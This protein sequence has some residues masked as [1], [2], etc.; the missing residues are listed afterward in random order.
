LS[1]TFFLL[2]FSGF[3]FFIYGKT[4]IRDEKQTES[5]TSERTLSASR[6][7]LPGSTAY[8]PSMARGGHFEANNVSSEVEDSVCFFTFISSFDF[9]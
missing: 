3:G 9:I 4:E 7:R 2:C 8:G 6:A 1:A 5:S